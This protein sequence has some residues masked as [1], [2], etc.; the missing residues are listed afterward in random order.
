MS[1]KN[2]NNT[3]SNRTHDQP[4]CSA[5]CLCIRITIYQHCN[6]DAK[7]AILSTAMRLP[8]KSLAF[9]PH[10]AH[11]VPYI[12]NHF[13]HW[14]DTAMTS[15][16]AVYWTPCFACLFSI[17]AL[18]FL[19]ILGFDP[20]PL[21]SPTYPF[22]SCPRSSRLSLTCGFILSSAPTPVKEII[23]WAKWVISVIVPC[24]HPQ[25]LG[26]ILFLPFLATYAYTV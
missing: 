21:I 22:F 19:I 1:M 5:V 16:A 4:A 7:S 25:L 6:A 15:W 9:C 13:G 24:V 18:P 12:N 26:G 23:L 10:P 2:C 20:S 14:A 11:I 3:I 8:A 17:F